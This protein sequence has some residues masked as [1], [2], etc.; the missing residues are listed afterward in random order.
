MMQKGPKRMAKVRT[1][2]MDDDHHKKGRIIAANLGRDN[3]SSLISYLIDKE[4]NEHYSEYKNYVLQSPN[5][6][7]DDK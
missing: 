5:D 4:W 7:E 6:E 1:I 2:T 3:F